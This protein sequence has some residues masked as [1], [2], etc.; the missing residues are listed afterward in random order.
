MRNGIV[1]AT[2]RAFIS[3][4]LLAFLFFVLRGWLLPSLVVI[5]LMGLF[6]P[7]LMFIAVG[8]MLLRVVKLDGRRLRLSRE[9]R[10]YLVCAA[11]LGVA[12][13]VI[14]PTQ[15]ARARLVRS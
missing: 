10:D 6:F 4:L 3:P 7:S 8:V 5:A 11:T 14:L 1:S 15:S 9:R 12:A 13:I 2:P